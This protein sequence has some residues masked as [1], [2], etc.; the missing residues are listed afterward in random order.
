[1]SGTY[2]SITD[3]TDSYN[4]DDITSRSYKETLTQLSRD[5][6]KHECQSNL[7]RNFVSCVLSECMNELAILS[8]I[9]ERTEQQSNADKYP[10]YKSI[11]ERYMGHENHAETRIGSEID[12]FDKLSND[13]G[14][15]YVLIDDLQ[16]EI[17]QTGTY[18]R[19]KTFIDAMRRMRQEEDQLLQDEVN[20]TKIIDDIKTTYE[21]ERLE[22]IRTIEETNSNIQ[23]LRFESE[24]V[25]LYGQRE[26]VFFEQWEKARLEQN[27]IR[28]E[29]KESSYSNIV[30]D[31]K[32]K[33]QLE[34]RCHKEFVAYLE[35]SKDDLLE[36]IQ[37]WMKR[38]DE[39]FEKRENDIIS[40]KPEL[41]KIK[42]E[43]KAVEERYKERSAAIEDFLEYKRVEAVKAEQ[44][45]KEVEAAVRIQAWWRGVMV[46]RKLG[47]YKKKK[48]KGGK[49]GDK[50]KAK[51]KK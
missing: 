19:L 40:L 36:D 31:A 4:V 48:G 30:T 20:Q 10:V 38:F 12:D 47:P 24:D 17:C 14:T 5:A 44:R 50:K 11:E 51:K 26:A 21:K 25:Y 46:R 8:S 39:D 37:A 6:N 1:M 2:I 16:K 34:N 42:E 9:V 41:E 23:K 28:C 49:D 7:V 3:G 33:M 35:E 29:E 45:R 18:G 43:R 22:N 15:I 27:D 13:I 32:E